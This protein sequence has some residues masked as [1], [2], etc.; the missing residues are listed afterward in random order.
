MMDLCRGY[1]VGLAVE[2]G[3]SLNNC[4]ALSNKAF[5]Y[6]LAGLAVLF[7]NTSGQ[8]ALALDIGESALLY[9]PGDVHALASGLTRWAADKVLLAKAK[10][11]AWEAAK[12]RWHW[13]HPLERGAL[14]DAVARTLGR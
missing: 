14:L 5:T 9:A 13:D 7:T 10:S 1:D 4:I 8:R 12:R 11:A 6:M 2:P 3:F